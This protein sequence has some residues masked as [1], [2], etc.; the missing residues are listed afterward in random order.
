[1][2][3]NG[4]VALT[5]V[6]Q[7][8]VVRRTWQPRCVWDFCSQG[9]PG[10]RETAEVSICCDVIANKRCKPIPAQ[11]PLAALLFT[12]LSGQHFGCPN[13]SNVVNVLRDLQLAVAL[14]QRRYDTALLLSIASQVRLEVRER[15]HTGLATLL[16]HEH[17]CNSF[18]MP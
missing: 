18:T 7:C 15:H 6:L 3:C 13:A 5:A 9:R 12:K 14:G 16:S 10:C 11:L 8:P 2:P 17:A 1:M 4:S